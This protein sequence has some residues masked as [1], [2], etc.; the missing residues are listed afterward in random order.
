MS[1]RITKKER[2]SILA[3]LMLAGGTWFII[4][5]LRDYFTTNFSQTITIG[6]GIGLI[7]FALWR[8]NIK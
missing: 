7:I 6:V 2:D 3:T 4:A 5:P 8:Y 1:R